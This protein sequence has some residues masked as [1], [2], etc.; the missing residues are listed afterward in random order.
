MLGGFIDCDHSKSQG[1]H[2]SG[3]NNNDGSGGCSRWMM[4]AA[5]SLNSFS[6]PS[7]SFLADGIS[8]ALHESSLVLL[9]FL[10]LL[11][12]TEIYLK[13]CAVCKP[14]LPRRRT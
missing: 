1:S 14:Q 8:I 3:E 5:V 6:F 13:Y 10:F 11:F 2:D 12:G 9:S 7:V 4:W